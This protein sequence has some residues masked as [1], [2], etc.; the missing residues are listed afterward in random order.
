MLQLLTSRESNEAAEA[1]TEN[2][3]ARKGDRTPPSLD[4]APMVH[5]GES[6]KN[7]DGDGVKLPE[8]NTENVLR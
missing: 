8:A 5:Q 4:I 3:L 7:A 2:H 1:Y 6:P